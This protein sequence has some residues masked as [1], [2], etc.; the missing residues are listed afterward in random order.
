METLKRFMLAILVVT[1]ALS[2]TPAAFADAGAAGES[3]KQLM[4]KMN[5][6]ENRIKQLGSPNRLASGKTL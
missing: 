3:D 4:N 2:S 1:F 6:L 5:R